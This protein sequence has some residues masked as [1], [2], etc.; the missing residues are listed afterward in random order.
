MLPRAN[1]PI[2]S[3][4]DQVSALIVRQ[5]LK[6]YKKLDIKNWTRLKKVTPIKHNLAVISKICWNYIKLSRQWTQFSTTSWTKA[7]SGWSA[8]KWNRPRNWVQTWRPELE[9]WNSSW[10]TREDRTLFWPWLSARFRWRFWCSG[11]NIAKFDRARGGGG[12]CRRLWKRLRSL[13]FREKR[14]GSGR[15]TSS[16]FTESGLP[17]SLEIWPRLQKRP[18]NGPFKESLKIFWGNLFLFFYFPKFSSTCFNILVIQQVRRKILLRREDLPDVQQKNIW[19]KIRY[20]RPLGEKAGFLLTW[21]T[22]S[23]PSTCLVTLTKP[24]FLNSAKA[25]KSWM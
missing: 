9:P 11:S 19:M 14:S 12:G 21:T 13:W 8:P 4:C 20:Q 6:C 2:K 16:T 15:G 23:T 1:R 5:I 3:L 17:G 18:R 10:K 22:S 25:Y 24:S 7:G